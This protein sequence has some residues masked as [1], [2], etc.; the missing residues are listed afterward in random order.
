MWSITFLA[1]NYQL[2]SKTVLTITFFLI[3][4]RNP[5]L[6]LFIRQLTNRLL[7]IIDL[8]LIHWFVEKKLKKLLFSIKISIQY[9]NFLMIISFLVLISQDWDYQIPANIASFN[10]PLMFMHNLAVVHLLRLG[11]FFG[12][13]Q[14]IRLSLAW[15]PNSKTEILRNIWPTS[16]MHGKLPS[17]LISKNL[18][19]WSVI[20]IVSSAG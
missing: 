2:C 3:F 18:V 15:R 12:H 4:G 7:I 20:F 14:S 11:V 10:S 8:F 17:K 6:F 9:L 13:I 19:K 5:I 1:L 16:T